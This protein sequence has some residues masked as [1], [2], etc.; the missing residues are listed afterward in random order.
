[1]EKSNILGKRIIC[2]LVLNLIVISAFSQYYNAFRIRITGNGYSDET[3]LRM[4]NGATPNFDGM[5]DAWKLFS[6][7]PNVPS[8]Y[9]Q[10]EPGQELSINSLPEYAEDISVNIF[11]NVPVDGIY[12][13]DIE[14]IYQLSSSY[15]ISLTDISS[16]THYRILGDTT[17]SFVLEAHQQ[18]SEFVFNISTEPVFEVN[19]ESCYLM[20]D[21]SLEVENHGNNDWELEIIDENNNIIENTFSNSSSKTIAN[22]PAGEYNAIVSSKGIVDEYA[23]T[24]LPA[25]ELTAEFDISEDTL[26]LDNGAFLDVTNLS[27]SADSYSWNFGDGNTST[28]HSPLHYY[29]VAGHF[30][31][32]LAVHKDNCVNQ[33]TKPITVLLTDLDVGSPIITSI[34]ETKNQENKMLTLGN[35]KY[36]FNFDHHIDGNAIV[37]DATG[38][39]IENEKISDV[40]YAI[41]LSAHKSGIYVITIE[42]EGRVMA[43]EK[44]I[45]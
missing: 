5:Y 22:L 23:F 12:T 18:L 9:T 36:Q 15:K 19:N 37:Y 38:K 45:R 4:L 16:N 29:N 10:V 14:Q 2:L 42:E 20:N 7:N 11:T 43:T 21:G 8:I 30:D 1:M 13:I 28:D 25:P 3:V 41:D 17:F 39:M 44:L 34:N 31:V 24:I 35:A 33:I 40:R 6:S 32:S 27:Q 26:Y